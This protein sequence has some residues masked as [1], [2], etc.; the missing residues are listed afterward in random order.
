MKSR[1]PHAGQGIGRHLPSGES[2]E[3]KNTPE[4]VFFQKTFTDFQFKTSQQQRRDGPVLHGRTSRTHCGRDDFEAVAKMI[5]R[6]AKE[7]NIIKADPKYQNRYPFSG[8]ITCGECGSSFK[9]RMNNTG[10]IKYA[11]WVCQEHITDITH[12]GMKAV[13]EDALERTFTMMMN[14]LIYGRKP[15]LNDLLENLKGE[16]HDDALREMKAIDRQLERNTER[17]QT[18][19]DIMAKGYLE[20]AVFAKENSGIERRTRRLPKR[21]THKIN[22][23]ECPAYRRDC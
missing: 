9:R 3:M 16:S 13:R 7:K 14:K 23:R 1:Y 15:V 6:H 8:K 22:E 21:T 10:N 12:C 4:T 18:L 11:S 17:K 20:P 19:R 5:E 2:R